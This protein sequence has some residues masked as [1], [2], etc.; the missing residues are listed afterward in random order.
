MRPP[1]AWQ[2]YASDWLAREDFRLASLEERGL[3]WTMLNQVWVSDSLPCD[4]LELAA[5][6]G[7]PTD[8]V[9]KAL[10]SRVMSAFAPATNDRLICPELK[11]MKDDYLAR[12]VER[13]RSGRKGAN[14]RW[15]NEKPSM[16]Q[17]SSSAMPTHEKKRAEQRGAE[18]RQLRINKTSEEEIE[19]YRRAFGET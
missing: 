17:P 12:R 9:S 14:K 4:S 11:A 3:L 5:L 13:S 15:Q 18:V 1:P 2:C 10:I 8:V 19:S 6:L 7:L 16:A